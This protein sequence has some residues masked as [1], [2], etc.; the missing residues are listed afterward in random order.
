MI[1]EFMDND[2]PLTSTFN[3]GWLEIF[4]VLGAIVLMAF[5]LFFWALFMRKPKNRKRKYR[6]QH[7]SYQEKLGQKATNVA[8][9]VKRRHGHRRH[10]YR[11]SSNPTLAETGG[12]PPRRPPESETPPSDAT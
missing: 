5:G 2:L 1:D 7:I 4:I 11:H 10:K 8:E 12:L 6:D 3:T 9:Y